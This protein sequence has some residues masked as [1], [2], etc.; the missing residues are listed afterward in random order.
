[1]SKLSVEQ[2]NY[3]GEQAVHV[4]TPQLEAVIV[5]AWGSNLIEL[6]WRETNTPLLRAPQTREQFLETPAL[7]GTPVLFP[8]NRID[9]GEFEFNGRTY[10]FPLNESNR[11]NHIHGVLQDIPW[12][13]HRA[14]V[15]GNQ[16]IV[17]TTVDSKEV[18]SVFEALPHHFTVKLQ[19]IFEGGSVIKRFILDNLDH[20]PLPWGVGYHTTFN[21][22]ISPEGSVERS[23]FKLLTDRIWELTDRLLPTGELVEIPYAAELNAGMSLSGMPLDTVYQVPEGAECVAVLTDPDA[24]LQITY[25]G[26]SHFGQWVVYNNDAKSGYLCPE[27]Y[28]WVTNAPHLSLPAELTGFR[29]LAPGGH[30]AADTRIDVV[31]L[32]PNKA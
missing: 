9:G 24:G 22:P 21:F 7:Y 10:R 26:D 1:M 20:E 12:K 32:A 25:S 17:E 13:L 16:A 18:P 15:E 19:L 27:P 28:T 8:P 2:I 4:S 3:L 11:G 6:N 31:A 29:A 14:E 30:V 5:P 23:T